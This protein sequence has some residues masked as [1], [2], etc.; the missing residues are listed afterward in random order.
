MRI[1]P[2]RISIVLTL[3]VA[4]QVSLTCQAPTHL[5]RPTVPATQPLVRTVVAPTP[6]SGQAT[7]AVPH[8][9]ATTQPSTP[10]PEP[11]ATPVRSEEPDSPDAASLASLARVDDYPLYTMVYYGPY[12]STTTSAGPVDG[13]R[14]PVEPGWACSLLAALDDPEER[15]FG[16]NFDWRYSPALLL[17]TDPPDGYASASMVDI[18]YLIGPG[19]AGRLTDVPIEARVPLLEAPL[20]PFD[21]MNE[22]GLGVGMA[23]V[24]ESQ[25]P[26]DPTK[27]TIGSLG[28][29]REILDQARD[30]EEALIVMQGYN[31]T[32]D[33]GPPLHYLMADAAGQAVLVE[34]VDGEMVLIPRPEQDPWHA[35][36]NHWRSGVGRGEASGCWRYA[37]IEEALA[38][39]AG[40]LT[41]AEALDLLADVSQ[42]E[43]Q[44]SVAYNLTSRELH[45]TMGR[46][47]EDTHVF[48]LMMMDE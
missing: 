1:K 16:R 20:W 37:T 39:T 44:W 2:G 10:S 4:A 40:R 8:V 23:A 19:D 45:V 14:R 41:A 27:P 6:T 17:F 38:R 7:G 26:Y 5:D 21:G 13:T 11:T 31:I 42:E 34:F 48:E 9:T 24:P 47:Y 35:A 22:H 15:V 28:I 18:A 33:G 3:A 32:W 46:D 12:T 43:T 29:I 30:V 25:M 36:T